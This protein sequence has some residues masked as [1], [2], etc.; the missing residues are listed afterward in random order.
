ML[1]AAIER[2]QISGGFPRPLHA[3]VRFS[4]S[5]LR[6]VKRRIVFTSKLATPL[7]T[8]KHYVRSSL[9]SPRLGFVPLD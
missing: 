6:S 3:N 7:A 9:H 4:G 5:R 2:R 8:A 1:I